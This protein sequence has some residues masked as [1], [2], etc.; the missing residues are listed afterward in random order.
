IYLE[1]APAQLDQDFVQTAE[2]A[3]GLGGYNNIPG[4]IGS[5]A[6]IIRFSRR[7]DQIVVTY[8]NTYFIAP[9]N[10][11]AQ[12]A[13]ARTVANSTVAVA[14][15]VAADPVTGHLVFDAS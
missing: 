4:G 12:R 10:Q 8:P 1:I 2:Q 11:A 5:Y 13:V 14:P 3:N 7:D 9:G 15:I 6:R